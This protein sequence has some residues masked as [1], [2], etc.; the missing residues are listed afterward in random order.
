[1]ILVSACLLGI[2]CRY[3]GM[4]KP[5]EAIICMMKD[6]I[7]LPVCPE[8]LGGLPTPRDAAQIVNDKVITQCGKDVTAKFQKGAREVLKIAGLYNIEKAI[9]KQ[10][11]PSC[12]AGII[13]DGTFSGKVINGDGVTTQL[14]KRNGI[15]VI[16]EESFK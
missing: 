13:Y 15:E 9:F 16:T 10:R 12:G 5:N 1:M 11:S 14:L 8:Q 7:L 2:C 6:D 3:D 4:S